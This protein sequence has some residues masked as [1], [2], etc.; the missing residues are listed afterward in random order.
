[1]NEKYRT[2]IEP[3][4]KILK[5]EYFRNTP[6]A[7]VA[8]LMFT[9]ETVYRHSAERLFF[10]RNVSRFGY[11]KPGRRVVL[12]NLEV[13]DGGLRHEL[14]HALMGFDFPS[15]PA[16]LQ[17]GMATLYEDAQ[18]AR[19]GGQS[20]LRPVVNWRLN[21]L[22]RA[23][24]NGRSVRLRRLIALPSLR[25]PRE[26]VYYAQARYLCFLL[27]ERGRLEDVYRTIRDTPC[28]GPTGGVAVRRAL[29]CADWDSVDTA[30]RTWVLALPKP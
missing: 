6:D 13:G 8:I 2:V 19:S 3:T 24:R 11:Y 26:G 23:L 18:S 28:E 17:E 10:D 22:Q 7:S 5:R 15:A 16:W 29:G 9:D 1:L 25:G 21:V 30:F 14:V 12:V 20:V 4:W 27:H